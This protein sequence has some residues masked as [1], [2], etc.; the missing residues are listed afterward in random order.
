M[1]KSIYLLLLLFLLYLVPSKAQ[2]STTLYY[3]V[4]V[5]QRA[6]VNPALR[7]DARFF[8]GM[9][10][11]S[12]LQVQTGNTGFSFNDA[13]VRSDTT[14]TVDMDRFLKQMPKVGSL[15]TTLNYQ[16]LAF[17]F[18]LL[19][20]GYFTFAM[21]PVFS[22]EFY[23]PRDLFGLAWK[24]NG[25]EDYLGKRISL[26]GTGMELSLTNEISLGYSHQITKRLTIGARY[27]HINGLVNIHTEKFTAGITTNEN[28]FAMNVDLDAKISASGPFVNF[29]SITS[30]DFGQYTTQ[31]WIDKSGEY[32]LKN[33]GYAI[34]IGASYM[35]FNRFF[36]SGS[37]NNIGS[38]TWAGNPFSIQT[39]GDFAFNGIDI[40]PMITG[41]STQEFDLTELLDSVMKS[42]SVDTLRN[43]YTQVLN[44]SVNLG[45][46][47]Y[48]SKDDAFGFLWRNQFYQGF[49]YPKM[50]L[51]YNHRFGRIL[52]LTAT[53]DIERGSYRNL[54]AGM[55]LKLGPYQFYLIT[56]NALAFA[57]PFDAKKV[58]IMTGMN[59]VFG[60][61]TKKESGSSL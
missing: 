46:A 47:F 48:L 57:Y 1:R 61:K 59:W 4:G 16:P 32:L 6:F 49:W 14:F 42:F 11:F 17:G 13:I 51:S 26:D 60:T 31:D 23:Y 54:G 25:H 7:P 18:R 40:T 9:P 28:T 29:D 45:A 33:Q 55:A 19:K 27:R 56:D 34:D 30:F 41:D 21:G 53:Y 20:R 58:T 39:K 5:P 8:M 2:H 52:S 38:I 24:G 36:F 50:T 3:M 15:Y 37:V 35:L 12:M 43:S 44:P 10:G 22:M